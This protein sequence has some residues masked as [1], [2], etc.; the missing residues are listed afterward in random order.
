MEMRILRKSKWWS[1]GAGGGGI[2][3]QI[4]GVAL[5]MWGKIAYPLFT[6]SMCHELMYLKL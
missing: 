6:S 3:G 4:D 1:G 5:V 2:M